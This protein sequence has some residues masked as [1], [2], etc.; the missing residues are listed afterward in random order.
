MKLLRFGPVGQEKPGLLDGDNAIRDLSDYIDDVTPEN[1]SA[2]S[3]AKIASLDWSLLPVVDNTPRLGSPVNGVGKIIAVG[4]NYMDHIKETGQEV[5]KEPIVFMK[6]TTA[7]SGPNDD[8]ITPRDSTMLD[9]EVELGI[10]IG[11]T[12]RYV[13]EQEASNFIAGYT[14]GNDVTDRDFQIYRGGQWTKGKSADTFAPMGPYLVVDSSLDVGNLDVWLE[15][16]GEV[17]QRSNTK[18]LIFDPA[19]LV[20]YLSAF[21]TL[22]PGDIILTGT[23]GGIGAF[24]TPP[25][26]LKPGDQVRL[27]ITGLGEQSQ[28]IVPFQ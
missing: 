23:P 12:A 25:R 27:G 18:H 5:P 28:K 4:L 1:L 2:E 8:V 22:E 14:I 10:V 15:L 7:L 16:N 24:Q 6:A 3:L 21:M 9:W 26:F 19:Y 17:Q 20:S 13:T 11:K